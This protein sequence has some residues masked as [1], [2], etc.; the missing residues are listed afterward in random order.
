MN[1]HRRILAAVVALA[2]T[3]LALAT[4]LPRTPLCGPPALGT[5]AGTSGE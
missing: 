5:G 2:G 4:A 3:V 1:H